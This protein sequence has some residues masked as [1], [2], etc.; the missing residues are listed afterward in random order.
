[1]RVSRLIPIVLLAA[2][3][4]SSSDD[5]VP[6]STSGGLAGV[7]VTLL[8]PVFFGSGTNAPAN[9][10]VVVENRAGVPI[11]IRNV[12]L[13]SSGM[14]S[15][16]IYPTQRMFNETINAGEA[17]AFPMFATASARSSRMT[18]NE[19]LMV[20]AVVQFDAG[21]ERYQEIYHGRAFEP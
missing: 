9:I 1:M 11:V 2:A 18:P 16:G 4:A 15:W 6:A 20:R 21:K 3:C 7:G 5:R 14:M 17:K 19:P 12:R 13:E 10:E 8:S